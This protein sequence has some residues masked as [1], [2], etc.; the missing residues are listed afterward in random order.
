MSI[1]QP[2]SDSFAFP[3]L[4]VEP[5][6][7]VELTESLTNPQVVYGL[8]AKVEP[9]SR[10]APTITKVD[11]SGF[12]RWCLFHALGQ[13]AA[14]TLPDGSVN[15]HEWVSANGFKSSSVSAGNLSDNAVRI[16]FLSPEQ[17]GGIGHVVLIVNGFTCESHGHKGVDR[18]AWG[19]LSFMNEMAVFCL[20]TPAT[21]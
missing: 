3:S 21:E 4:A 9:L 10:Q 2:P 13:P 7:I 1:I 6:K 5:A 8:G 11:C 18:R 12:V 15:Q 20:S 16:A 14:Y 17:A 19:S